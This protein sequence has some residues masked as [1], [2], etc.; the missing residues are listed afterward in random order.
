[1][2]F[3]SFQLVDAGPGKGRIRCAIGGSGPPLLLLH[4][5]PETHLMWRAVAPRLA[6][7]FTLICADLPGQ[8][9]SAPAADDEPEPYS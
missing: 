4:G 9:G 1:M 6:E 2:N 8:G 5:F 3:D 7:H